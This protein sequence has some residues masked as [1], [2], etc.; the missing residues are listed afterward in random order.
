MAAA[1]ETGLL[2]A[3]VTA[4]T[5][6]LPTATGR[7][8]AM[9]PTTLQAL[10]ATLLFLPIAGLRRPWDLR[11][12]TGTLLP[13]LTGQTMAYGYE[14][15]RR[16]LALLARAGAD[17]ALSP[18]LA[19]WTTQ[20]WHSDYCGWLLPGVIYIDSHKKAVHSDVLIPRGRI[21]KTGKIQGCRTLILI[22]DAAGH[23]LFVTTDRGDQHLIRGL[24]AAV[25]AYEQASGSTLRTLIVDREGMGGDFVARMVAEQRVVVTIL[26][27]TQYTGLESFHHVEP[28]APLDVAPDGRVLREVARAQF[29]LT[30]PSRPDQPLRLNV[31]LIRDYRATRPTT[32]AVAALETD[33][34]DADWTPHWPDRPPEPRLIP[35]VTTGALGDPRHL[36]ALY[37][38][39][40]PQQENV[41]RDWLIPLQIEVNAGRAKTPVVNSEAQARY[42]RCAVRAD[43]L[44]D[45]AARAQRTVADQQAA[46]ATVQAHATRVGDLVLYA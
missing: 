5:P 6:L 15:V 10:L 1:H 9:H 29:D 40:W 18:M 17:Q 7:L 23:P 25:A 36:V 42:D 35:I 27:T 45:Q 33:W 14:H 30:V 4:I 37:Q 11:T 43:R 22:H 24:P 3:L 38:G 2:A 19:R 26:R 39:R 46:L 12:A 31:A 44:A 32:D 8:A 20:L 34:L 21:G 28:F 16:F 13:L 41:I